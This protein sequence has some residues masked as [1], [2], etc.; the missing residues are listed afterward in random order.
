MLKHHYKVLGP[1]AYLSSSYINKF[2][3]KEILC[4]GQNHISAQESAQYDPYLLFLEI[5]HNF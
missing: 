5:F 4:L 2:Q 1:H 3:E